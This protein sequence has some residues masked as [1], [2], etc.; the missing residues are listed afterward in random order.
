MMLLKHITFILAILAAC[1]IAS[2]TTFDEKSCFSE[3]L[4]NEWKGWMLPLDAS[5]S[6]VMKEHKRKSVRRVKKISKKST[7]DDRPRYLSQNDANVA[8]GT[9]FTK[10]PLT[11]LS[12]MIKLREEAIK[13]EEVQRLE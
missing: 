11:I 8:I 10:K 12:F 5:P 6:P 4:E 13:D 1:S 9:T 7:T 2:E 3:L